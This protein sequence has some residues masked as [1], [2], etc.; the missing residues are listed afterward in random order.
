V[1]RYLGPEALVFLGD[2]LDHESPPSSASLNTEISWL[3]CAEWGEPS[4]YRVRGPVSGTMRIP[5]EEPMAPAGSRLAELEKLADR[6]DSG[7]LSDEEVETEKKRI[8]E[9]A[10]SDGPSSRP[11]RQDRRSDHLRQRRVVW[12]VVL[13]LVIAAAV[14]IGVPQIRHQVPGIRDWF[15]GPTTTLRGDVFYGQYP[16]SSRGDACSSSS[17]GYATT[18]AVDDNVGTRVATAALS[19][20]SVQPSGISRS[21]DNCVF[22]FSAAVPADSAALT[23]TISG[24]TSLTFSQQTLQQNHW[25]VAFNV[26]DS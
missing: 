22:A 23:I 14:V 13:V 11:S 25:M 19:Q 7:D 20:G 24:V 16:T 2:P 9:S 5:R 18:V 17:F 21:N 26:D 6:R 12:A 15:G 1:I 3:Y 4:I 10:S 8:L